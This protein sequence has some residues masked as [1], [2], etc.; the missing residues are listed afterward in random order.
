MVYGFF[1]SIDLFMVS[2]LE[3]CFTHVNRSDDGHPFLHVKLFGIHLTSD[4]S[5]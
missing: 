4:T 3:W 5:K 2:D 1:D